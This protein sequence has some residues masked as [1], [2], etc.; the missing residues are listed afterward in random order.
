MDIL[1]TCDK[2]YVRTTRH[3]AAE[4]LDAFNISYTSFDSTY[5]TAD[6][7][8][9]LYETIAHT[10]T[11]STGEHVAYIVPGSAVFAEKSVQLIREYAPCPVEVIPAVSFMDGLF[12]AIGMDAADS[13]KLIDALRIDRQHP[14]TT[15]T[16]VICQVYDND[17]ASDLKL[18]L[19]AYYGDEQEVWIVSGAATSKERILKVKL[20]ELDRTDIIDHL[21]TVVIPPADHKRRDFNDFTQIIS[22]LRSEHGCPWD[23]AQTH[24]SLTPYIIEEA[25]EVVD[26]IKNGDADNLC[27]E[28]GDVLLQVMLHA[29]I[30][31]ENGAFDISD[32]V[33]NVS[34]KMIRRHPH[35][36]T[37]MRQPADINQMWE[38]IKSGEHQYKTLS[39]VLGGV[40]RSLPALIYA[41]KIQKKAAKIG[42]DFKDAAEASQKISEELA[43][44]FAAQKSGDTDKLKEEAGD[45]LFA[46]VNTVRLMDVAA[47]EALKISAGKFIRRFHIMEE[48]C[49]ADQSDITR[50]GIEQMN[51]Y[52]ERA[53]IAD[54]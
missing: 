8:D 50:I 40:A 37:D 5:D 53:K 24:E 32:V 46:A 29:E 52:W 54:S 51:D 25:Y 41:Q 18:A 49:L 42:F 15:T 2:V 9:A 30:A 6:N 3:P 12:A 16:N 48:L 35:V 7:F 38:D 26:A 23:K 43:E 44:L 4:I 45:L 34:E 1:K 11:Q 13:F 27:E 39:D 36:F 22:E 21:T 10:V 47:E 31:K 14:D 20:Y 33:A 19:M 28:L 17:V